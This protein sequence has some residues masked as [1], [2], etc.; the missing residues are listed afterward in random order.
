MSTCKADVR[1]R[2]HWSR[3]RPKCGNKSVTEAGYCR[4]HDPQEKLNRQCAR[5]PTRWELEQKNR[6]RARELFEALAC[7]V[8]ADHKAVEMLNELRTVVK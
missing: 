7:R 5:P 1:S 6:D 4:V 8:E 2:D 3:H